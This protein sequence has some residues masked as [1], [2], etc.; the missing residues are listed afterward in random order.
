[1]VARHPVQPAQPGEVAGL[2]LVAV[3][4]LA[5]GIGVNTAIFS[6]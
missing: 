1:M 2:C 6:A 5:L 4:S 3:V